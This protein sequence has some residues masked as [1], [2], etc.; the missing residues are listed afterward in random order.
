MLASFDVTRAASTQNGDSAMP[1]AATDKPD[2]YIVT[3]PVITYRT[4]NGHSIQCRDTE[5]NRDLA[6]RF[7]GI[8]RGFVSKVGTLEECQRQDVGDSSHD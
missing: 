2:R 5:A 7:E 4:P 3:W 6:P 1:I 8:T